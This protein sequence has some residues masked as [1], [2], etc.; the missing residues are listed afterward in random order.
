MGHAH[1]FSTHLQENAKNLSS[2]ERQLLSFARAL[3]FSPEI[4]IMDEATSAVDPKTERDIQFALKKLLKGRTSI[5]IAHRLSTLR[6]VDNI[7]V[8]DQGEIVEEGPPDTL[9]NTD[10]YFATYYRAQ[11]RGLNE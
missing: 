5:I 1:G 3:T 6:H 4:L 7:I 2:G 9:L 8:L 11:M 10:G